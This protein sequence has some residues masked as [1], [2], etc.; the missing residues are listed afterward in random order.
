VSKVAKDATDVN[1][2]SEFYNRSRLH[3]LSTM[4]AM[5]KQYVG[6]LKEKHSGVFP[7]LERLKL[8]NSGST[9]TPQNE[10]VR[11]GVTLMKSFPAT[12]NRKCNILVFVLNLIL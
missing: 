1:F 5:L 11:D 2:I 3:H 10:K 12:L 8:L 6:E 7:G 4:G 9:P